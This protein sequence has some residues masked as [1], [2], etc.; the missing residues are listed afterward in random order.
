MSPTFSLKIFLN[1]GEIFFYCRF[2]RIFGAVFFIREKWSDVGNFKNRKENPLL[3]WIF[4]ERFFDDAEL[5]GRFLRRSSTRFN[6]HRWSNYEH[7]EWSIRREKQVVVKWQNSWVV[8]GA[9][10]MQLL[11][12]GALVWSSCDQS[13]WMWK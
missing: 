9:E 4:Y 1:K 12:H 11:Q 7:Y 2:K 6:E 13:F 5:N 10:Y 3:W 8:G